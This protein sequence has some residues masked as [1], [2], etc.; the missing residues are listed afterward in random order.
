[1]K[2]TSL[3]KLAI[4]IGLCLPAWLVSLAAGAEDQYQMPAKEAKKPW[5]VIL[6]A[7]VFLLASLVVAFKHS[8]RTHLD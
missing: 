1:M 6:Y 4:T 3:K 2:V 8:K 7:I 5:F